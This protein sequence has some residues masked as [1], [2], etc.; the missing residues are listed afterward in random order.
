MKQRNTRHMQTQSTI[1]SGR[2]VIRIEAEA[3]TLLEKRIG[4]SFEAAVDLIFSSYGRVV[5]TGVGKSGL[6]ARKIVATMNSTG[7]PAIFL[8]PADAVHGDLGIVRQG[9]VV[10]ILSKS[11]N[12]GEIKNIF[13]LFKQMNVKIISIVGSMDSFLAGTSDVALD[14][15]V[16]EEAC[17][18]DLAPTAS[19][20]VALAL[21]DALAIALL[22]KRD[23]TPEDFAFFHPGG[24]IGKRLLLKLGEIML[25]DD[26]VPVVHGTVSLKDAIIEMTSKRLGA[27]CV[28][29][30]EGV[31]LGIITDG[32]LRRLLEKQS[33]IHNLL[34]VEAMTEH[35]K[36]IHPQALASTAL[37]IME[38][39]KITQLIVVNQRRQPVGIVHVHDLIQL[40]LR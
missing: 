1:E 21:G 13:P 31:L 17:P 23:F 20:T 7:T 3:L 18:H 11:G 35:P 6:I 15:S 8:H 40:G 16:L 30:D 28:V 2:A 25:K 36:T 26:A 19:T 9:D 33:D 29:D 5:V 37:E 38:Q 14:G 27:T 22:K 32:D 24:I 10:I 4:A 34:A 39:Y 12:T